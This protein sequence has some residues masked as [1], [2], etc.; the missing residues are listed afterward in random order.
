MGSRTSLTQGFS[1]QLLNLVAFIILS[2][3]PCVNIGEPLIISDRGNNVVGTTLLS[4][5]A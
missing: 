2:S 5:L 4:V 1:Y 3:L